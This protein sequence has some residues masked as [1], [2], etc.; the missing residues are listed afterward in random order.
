M[1]KDALARW[2][3]AHR[4]EIL[5]DYFALLRFPS[6]GADPQRLGDCDACA[7]WIQCFLEKLGFAVE[8][9]R[10][11]PTLPALVVTAAERMP[12]FHSP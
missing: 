3:D 7:E 9:V 4:A 1:T 10:Q 8:L 6:I 5:A 11:E 2:F 12:V